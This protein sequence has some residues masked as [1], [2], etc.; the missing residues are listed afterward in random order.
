MNETRVSTTDRIT[1]SFEHREQI[2]NWKDKGF[3]EGTD[4][5]QMA[6][7]ALAIGVGNPT[8]FTNKSAYIRRD[9]LDTYDQ[10]IYQA[11]NIG[12]NYEKDSDL[13]ILTDWINTVDYCNKC[14]NTGLDKINQDIIQK[15]AGNKTR[16]NDSDKENI[17]LD[18]LDKL[19]DLYEKNIEL[20]L[21]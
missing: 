20:N 11:V 5:N 21:D 1:I 19:S 15:Y 12:N 3:F 6:T 10:S 9:T 16:I 7:I 18:L 14:I 2:V 17:C 8:D 13:N 4:T